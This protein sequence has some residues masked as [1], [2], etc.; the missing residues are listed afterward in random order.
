[1]SP[2]IRSSRE[3]TRLLQ[4]IK[5]V[6]EMRFSDV[7][8]ELNTKV[9]VDFFNKPTADFISF[10]FIVR[11]CIALEFKLDGRVY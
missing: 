11:N 1:M 7:I 4:T 8:F 5:C 3:A 2:Y 9:V 10:G 6:V